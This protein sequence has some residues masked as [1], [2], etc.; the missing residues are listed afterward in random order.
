MPLRLLCW[1]QVPPSPTARLPRYVE[2]VTASRVFWAAD[3]TKADGIHQ[4]K[5]LIGRYTKH[6]SGRIQL[7]TL[8]QKLKVMD[9]VWGVRRVPLPMLLEP[10]ELQDSGLNQETCYVVERCYPCKNVSD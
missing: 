2:A 1:G 3:R 8:S 6:G 7:R 4:R 5:G 10:V 9:T